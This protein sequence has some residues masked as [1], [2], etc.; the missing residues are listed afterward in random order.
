MNF[1]RRFFAGRRP[2]VIGHRG[3]AGEAPENTIASF[4]L[5]VAG[6][7]DILEMDVHL[8][9]D[10]YV[11]VCHDPTVDRTTNGHGR[12]E[13]MTLAEVQALDAGYNFCV[14]GKYPY[15]SKGIVIP[16]FEEVLQRYPDKPMNVEPKA[17][18]DPASTI[19]KDELRE[20]FLALLARYGRLYDGS[21]VGAGND[22][23]VVRKM[24][25]VLDVTSCSQR[26]ITFFVVMTRLHLVPRISRRSAL[27]VPVRKGGIEI[28]TP[29]FIR[30]AHARGIEVHVWTINDEGEMRRLLNMGV[31]ALFTDFPAKMRK[32]VDSEYGR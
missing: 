28:V 12:I 31:D 7:A 27:Q 26:E 21:V 4:D 16:L 20:L 29:R 2:R 24:R 1:T 8:T 13:D 17:D 10:K 23:N 9:K 3:A 14:D 18:D 25:R 32:L 19:D 15:R 5:A 6:G 22:H 30:Y 11:V